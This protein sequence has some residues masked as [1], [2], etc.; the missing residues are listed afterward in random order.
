MS[1][2]VHTIVGPQQSGKTTI[3][4]GFLEKL[5]AA[6][7]SVAY[8]LPTEDWARDAR[9]RTH[10]ECVSWR[11]ALATPEAPWRAI[12]VEDLGDMPP[13][14]FA[15]GMLTLRDRLSAMGGPT[16]LLHI[17]SR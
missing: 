16:Q 11:S 9:H 6:G 5:H 4:L 8:V 1:C 17:V 10:V 2:A 7:V 15:D 3:A 12:A 13:E 14:Q